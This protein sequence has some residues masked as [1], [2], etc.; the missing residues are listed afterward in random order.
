MQS[1]WSIQDTFV[2]LETTCLSHHWSCDPAICPLRPS[3]IDPES[4]F[5]IGLALDHAGHSTWEASQNG[6]QKVHLLSNEGQ[7]VGL[8]HQAQVRA[9]IGSHAA[10]QQ[11]PAW[12]PDAAYDETTGSM[13]NSIVLVDK[14]HPGKELMCISG[15]IADPTSDSC[16]VL[17]QVLLLAAGK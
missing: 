5:S 14:G 13:P 8:V 3:V 16:P 2:P 4:D 9:G 17:D 11:R 7:W 12:I 6:Y 10:V 1:N 15:S